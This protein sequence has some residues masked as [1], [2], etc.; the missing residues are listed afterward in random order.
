MVELGN[1]KLFR[2]RGIVVT[3]P[4]SKTEDPG[5]ESHQSIRSLYIAVVFSK[6][7]IHCRCV[8]LRK[9][10]ALKY[11][12]L[13]KERKNCIGEDSNYMNWFENSTK[14]IS[15]QSSTMCLSYQKLQILVYK[16]FLLQIFV[17]CTFY[18]F[19]TF[20]QYSLVRQVLCNYFEPIFLRILANICKKIHTFVR[21]SY[22]YEQNWDNRV[23]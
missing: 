16:Y 23:W 4:T 22:Q 11:F 12:F 10:N 15:Q 8:H 5:F 3:E 7:K 19:V 18:I 17:V 21:K 1:I 2:R 6:L 14:S 9:I 20:N 13:R